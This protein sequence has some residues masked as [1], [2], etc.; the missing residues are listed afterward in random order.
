MQGCDTEESLPPKM[1]L[2][3]GITLGILQIALC[4]LDILCLTRIKKTIIKS[5]TLA[6]LAS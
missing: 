5:S 4:I 3:S 6:S 2:M 1:E